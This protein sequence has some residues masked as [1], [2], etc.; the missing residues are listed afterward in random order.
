[1]IRVINDQ[2]VPETKT[3]CGPMRVLTNESHTAKVNLSELRATQN[4]QPHYHGWT[5]EIYRVRS[6]SGSIRVQELGESRRDIPVTAGTI[7]VIEPRTIHQ[8]RPGPGSCSYLLIEVI[9]VPAW[10]K[11]DEHYLLPEKEAAFNAAL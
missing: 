9:A 10:A 3:A 1:M 5:T 8:V 6:G 11:V 4:S 7:L 2:E